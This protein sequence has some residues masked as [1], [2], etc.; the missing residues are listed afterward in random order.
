[1]CLVTTYLGCEATAIL[2]ANY[3]K[4]L[5]LLLLLEAYKGLLPNRGD[6]LNESVSL[7]D[8]QNLFQQRLT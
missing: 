3:D 2:M 6:Y 7:M 5:L 1:M 4:Q 8:F